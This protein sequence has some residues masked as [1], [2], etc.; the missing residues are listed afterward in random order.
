MAL[1]NGT[2]KLPINA[3]LR[4]LIGKSAG[5]AVTVRLTERLG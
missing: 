3:A 1:G 5:D 2:H 4:K